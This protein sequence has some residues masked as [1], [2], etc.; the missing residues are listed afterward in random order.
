VSWA[1]EAAKTVMAGTVPERLAVKVTA[2][3]AR[4][5]SSWPHPP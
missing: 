1:F 4:L 5:W 2:T 3:G